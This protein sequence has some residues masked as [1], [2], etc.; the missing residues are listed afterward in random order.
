MIQLSQCECFF[1]KS[2]AGILVGQGTRRQNLQSHISIQSL[3]ERTVHH[4]HSTGANLF[5]DA[6]MA[7][8]LA[9]ELGG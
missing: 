6:V 9:N 7:E 5:N 1:P 2:L 3:V 8:S 4:A